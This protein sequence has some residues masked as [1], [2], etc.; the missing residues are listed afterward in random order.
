MRQD[1]DVTRPEQTFFAADEKPAAP[2]L[3]NVKV[4]EAAFWEGNRPRCSELGPAK[5]SAADAQRDE[6]VAQQVWAVITH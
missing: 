3:N 2:S 6:H 4:G 1:D 5:H